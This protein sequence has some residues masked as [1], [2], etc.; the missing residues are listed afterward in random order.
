MGS[1]NTLPI[2]GESFQKLFPITLLCLVLFN[3]FNVYGRVMKA[4]GMKDLSLS[5]HNVHFQR[6]G[7]QIL[8]KG[9]LSLIKEAQIAS[10][11]DFQES[12]SKKGELN[13][14]EII[15]RG[16]IKTLGFGKKKQVLNSS[17][18]KQSIEI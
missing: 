15:A 2:F 13:I 6:E 16:N 1:S 10:D 7:N 12:R 9:I 3:I 18:E 11:L 4:L 17:P 8:K 14:K 5:H